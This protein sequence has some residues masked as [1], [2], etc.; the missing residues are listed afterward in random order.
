MTLDARSGQRG[1]DPPVL[2]TVLTLGAESV[3]GPGTEH[4]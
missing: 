2:K 3:A 1:H 4:A